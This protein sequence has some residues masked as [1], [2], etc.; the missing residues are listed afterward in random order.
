VSTL[1]SQPLSQLIKIKNISLGDALPEGIDAKASPPKA[2]KGMH[3]NARQ[4]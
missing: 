2:E 1:P 4:L 3:L